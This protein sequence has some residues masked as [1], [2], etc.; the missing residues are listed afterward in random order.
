MPRRDVKKGEDYWNRG[1][2]A[3][4]SQK[5][6]EKNDMIYADFHEIPDGQV[7][8]TI[9][10]ELEKEKVSTKVAMQEPEHGTMPSNDDF[11]VHLAGINEQEQNNE[12]VTPISTIDPKEM[13]AEIYRT[14]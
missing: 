10:G 12:D 8:Y 7:G 2:D 4:K 9:E 13:A 5:K 14:G 3:A 6:S 11:A 1:R